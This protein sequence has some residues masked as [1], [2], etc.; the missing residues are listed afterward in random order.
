M[1]DLPAI[2]ESAVATD[3][4][5]YR[6]RS[7]ADKRHTAMH[8]AALARQVAN[9][10]KLAGPESGRIDIEANRRASRAPR[11]TNRMTPST[12]EHPT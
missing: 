7:Q 1:R 11:C 4:V 5:G 6:S 8:Y 9:E 12:R 2:A 10:A 3:I